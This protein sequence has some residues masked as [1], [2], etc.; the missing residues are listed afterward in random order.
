MSK[1]CQ[2]F[3]FASCTRHVS[4]TVH[5]NSVKLYRKITHL[6]KF[7]NIRYF[8]DLSKIIKMMSIFLNFDFCSSNTTLEFDQILQGKCIY[9]AIVQLKVKRLSKISDSYM[10]KSRETWGITPSL[11]QETWNCVYRTSNMINVRWFSSL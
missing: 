3:T 8:F 11:M 1:V 6:V 4:V 5:Y 10:S 9:S 2:F 7:C